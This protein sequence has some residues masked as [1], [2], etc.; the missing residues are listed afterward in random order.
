L[1]LHAEE[2][3]PLEGYMFAELGSTIDVT[4]QNIKSKYE[5]FAESPW[6]T[7]KVYPALVYMFNVAQNLLRKT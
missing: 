5:D 7:S 2:Q 6:M 1:G 3:L 4:L